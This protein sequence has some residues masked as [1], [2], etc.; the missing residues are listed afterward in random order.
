M[1]KR[2]WISSDS[3][4]VFIIGL[5]ALLRGISYMP[6]M[7]SPERPPAHLL[8]QVAPPA[9]WAW[10][11]VISGGAVLYGDYLPALYP[12]RGRGGDR[13]A[14]PVG[15]VFPGIGWPRLGELDWVWGRYCASALG[16]LA[17]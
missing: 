10:P 15:R 16:V 12:A 9:L 14:L 2:H 4:G 11:W 1:M 3:V 13:S 8:E 7:V 5:A 6:F 17:R